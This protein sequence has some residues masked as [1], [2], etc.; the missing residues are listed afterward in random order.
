MTFGFVGVGR[1]GGGLARNLIR[2]GKEVLVYDLDPSAVRKTIEAGATGKPAKKAAEVAAADVVIVTGG[3]SVGEKDSAK[4]MFEPTG[5]ELIFSKVSI[6]PGKPVWL[7]RAGAALVMGLPGNPTSALVTARL[8][9]APLL[10][11]LS[12][13]DPNEPLRWRTARLAAPLDECGS[14][15]TFHRARWNASAIVS[16]AVWNYFRINHPDE[17]HWWRTMLA[18]VG[19]MAVTYDGRVFGFCGPEMAKMFCYS[20]ATGTWLAVSRV[21]PAMTEVTISS[22]ALPGWPS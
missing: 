3:A 5:I 13:R 16:I 20:P 2:A 11:G 18:P 21:L 17:Q 22:C 8:L 12:G 6:K 7:G 1:M 15:E 19:P 10:A 14:R 4:T 9:L